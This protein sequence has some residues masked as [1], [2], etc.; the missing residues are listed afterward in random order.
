M[1]PKSLKCGPV[2]GDWIME[3]LGLN[4]TLG[5]RVFVRRGDCWRHYLEEGISLPWSSL[6]SL[7][8]STHDVSSPPP[9]PSTMPVLAWSQLTM[10]YN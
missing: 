3:V 5:N 9:D 2:E 7:L 6:L 8:P 10:D 1:T 4:M